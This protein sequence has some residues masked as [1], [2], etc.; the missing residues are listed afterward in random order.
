M[1]G[2]EI[3]IQNVLFNKTRIGFINVLKK[4]NA[5]ISISNIKTKQN[6]KTADISV[7]YS[8]KLKGVILNKK[9]VV[10]MIDEIPIFA[11]IA[12]YA[13]G[14]TKVC[15]ALELRYKESDRI[16]SMEEGLIAVGIKV[17]S[18]IDSI[19]INGG[20]I[21][22]GKIN[23]Y[24]DHRIAMAFAIAALVSKKSITIVDTQNISTSFPNFIDLMR[25]QWAN[26]YEL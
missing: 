3:N 26:V 9:E 20:E 22:G 7:K 19:E 13:D 24:G 5:K 17:T 21:L 8:Q 12:C 11:L 1:K 25:E 10:N 16:K 14:T 18:T 6:E 4:M 23:S 15:D 2:S